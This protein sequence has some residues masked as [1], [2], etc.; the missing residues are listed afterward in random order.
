M[1][2]G[3]YAVKALIE[4]ERHIALSRGVLDVVARD[5]ALQHSLVDIAPLWIETL[6]RGGKIPLA[7][8]GGSVSD[9]QH[10]A[11]ELLLRLDFDRPALAGFALTTHASVLA[12]IRNDYG[13]ENVFERIGLG[14]ARD[15][16]VSIS[17][18]GNS[19]DIVRVLLATRDRGLKA[20][21]LTGRGGRRWRRIAIS[22]SGCPRHRRR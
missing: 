3:I 20:V 12:A 19:P 16:F 13:Y 2:H 9:A 1:N 11:G 22:A 18:S 8:N 21:G 10:I 5:R 14:R 17:R 15:C 7:G 4:I 6:D